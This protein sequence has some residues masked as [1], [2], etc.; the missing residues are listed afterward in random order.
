[1]PSHPE[2]ASLT[3]VICNYNYARF[4]RGAID[5]A[6]AQTQTAPAVKVMVIDDGSTDG[7]REILHGY[8]DRIEAICQANGGQVSAYNHAL[9]RV[10]TP[11]VIF[12]DA[13]DLLEP[14]AA[15]TVLAAFAAGDYAKVQFRLE[16]MT[17]DGTLT[18]VQVPQ[19][20]AV[21]DCGAL[22]RQGWLY[23][24]PPGSG[25]AY[26]VEA[27]RRIFPVPVT[28]DNIHG[29]DFYA[30]YGTALVGDVFAIDR[31]LGRYRVHRQDN[32][33]LS[34]ANAEDALAGARQSTRRWVLLREIARQRLGITLPAAPLDFAL[35]KALFAT[36]LYG[37]PL[38]QRWRWFL[39]ESGRYFHTV[40]ANPYW[41][42]RK[43]VAVSGLTAL[44]LVPVA[45]V[46]DRAI[47]YIANPLARSGAPVRPVA[48]AGGDPTIVSINGR[49]LGRRPT[50]VDR[51]ANEVIRSID[52]LVATQA[53]AVAGLSFEL[54]IPPSVQVE[55]ER[56]PNLRIRTVPGGNGQY[57]EQ[58]CLPLAARGTLLL[59]LCN[60]GPL[61]YRN[62]VTVMH[63]AA[64]MR[65]PQAYT[66]AFRAWYR[67]MAPWIGRIA[68]RVLTVSEF[69]R[70]ELIQAYHI[71]GRKIG[72]L[73]MSG[74]HMLRLP[75][76]AD[77]RE[78]FHLSGRPYI[79]A[80]SSASHHKNFRLVV[81]AIE[82]LK[83]TDYDVVIVGGGMP[84]LKA[85][86]QVSPDFVKRVGYVDDG[87]LKALFRQAAC[88]VFPSLYEGF[89]LP[90][91]EAMTLGCPVIASNLPSVREA[92]GDAAIYFRPT[93]A[94]ECGE[95]MMH[96]MHDSA[97]R[98]RLR[99]QGFAN[100]QRRS[101]RLT[102]DRLLTE[103][104]PWLPQ[105]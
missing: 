100:V 64:P 79:L 21:A 7:S 17:G 58:V 65:V 59:N 101:W 34:L 85:V 89:G 27:L 61:L 32:G 82:L 12:L 26:R 99:T 46:G 84:M 96:V 4:L 16:V 51:F 88:F 69:S 43:K 92:C 87:D 10:T 86:Q 9:R 20:N 81:E 49:Y 38:G 75:E 42:L 33:G 13:D 23:P 103:I 90:P 98:D 35:E 55:P 1:M 29:A 31:P 56:F 50:G 97:L 105:R 45:A 70:G 15:A 72:V 95:A 3:I 80:V 22:L 24:S 67:M 52:E 2:S 47:R 14:D 71:P 5:S 91:V 6:L 68:R 77:V 73:P 40:T 102:A 104:S 11:Y 44:A 18:G 62:Q 28:A 76:E 63:D 25:N 66:R 36:A 94:A 48:P 8:G 78:K 93:S 83:A 39:R 37:A 54:L 53:P 74:D 19:S 60:A 41:S 30:I 57:W